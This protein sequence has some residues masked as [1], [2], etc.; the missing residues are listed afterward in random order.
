MGTGAGTG[1]MATTDTTATK[2]QE[3]DQDPSQGDNFV[4]TALFCA[5][6]EGNLKGLEE[7]FTVSNIDANQSNRHGE[8]AAHVAAGLGQLDILK[9][10]QS[11]GADLE[12][13]DNH[14]DSPMYWAARQGQVDIIKYLKEESLVSGDRNKAGESYLHVAARYGHANAVQ[15]LCSAGLDVNSQDQHGETALHIA[16]WHGFPRIVQTLCLAGANLNVLDK[17]EETP[18]HCA[19][20][21][22]HVD[23]VRCLIE[24]GANLDLVDKRGCTALHLAIKRH[25]TQVALL[26][27]HAGCGIDIP[28]SHHETPIHLVAREGNLPLA[29]TLCAFG[30]K[31]DIPNKGGFYPLH[32]AAKHAHIEIVRCLCLAGCKVDQKN[33]DGIIAEITALAQGY[34][35]IGDLLNK[36]QN[37]QLREEY[38]TQLIPGSQPLGRIK[39][40]F[41]GHSGVGKTTFVDSLKCGYFGS[42]FRRSRSSS[43]SSLTLRGQRGRSG[44]PNSKSTIELS[45][46]NPATSS[47][48]FD[49]PTDHY[50]RGIDVQ[51]ITV[52]GVGDV[53]VWEFS[54]QKPYFVVYD[55][56]IGNTN[57]IH[58]ILFNLNDPYDVQLQQV[59]FWLNFLLVRI[60]TQEPL[61]FCGKSSCPAKVVL[62]ATH[63]D[64][65]HCPRNATGEF[66]NSQAECLLYE[67]RHRFQHAFDIHDRVYV[68]SAHSP[69]NPST[70]AF[71]NFLVETKAKLVQSLPKSTGFLE[72]MVSHLPAWCRS[73]QSFP[74]LSWHQFVEM[75]HGQ[76]N[77]LAGEDHMRELIQQLQLMGEVLYLKS[78]SQDMVVLNPRWLCNTIV[79]Q[80]LS[81]QHLEQARVTGCYT[82]DD[83]QLLFP[84]LDALD[85]LQVLESLN[86]CTQCDN[87]G[88]IEYE[89]PCFNFVETLPGLWEKHDSRYQ[90]AVYGGV[91]IQTPKGTCHLLDSLFLRL[92][93]QLRRTAQEHHDPDNDL[94]QWYRGSKFCSGNLEGLLTLED[95]SESVEIK[96]RGPAAMRTACFYFLEDLLSV[97]D[98][99]VLEMCPSLL[100]EKHVLSAH[101][102]QGHVGVDED[103]TYEPK[104]LMEA[105]LCGKGAVRDETL[106]ELLC[107]GSEELLEGATVGRDLHVGALGVLVRQQLCR[108]LDPPDPMG[109]DWCLLAVQLGMVERLP[110]L[111]P[112][113]DPALLPSC[114]DRI[115]REWSRLPGSTVGALLTKLQGLGRGDT[116]DVLLQHCPLYRT[117]LD[118]SYDDDRHTDDLGGASHGSGNSS[119]NLSR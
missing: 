54:G 21:R 76:V 25:H 99:V 112:G 57:C 109:R 111:D 17:E 1:T 46:Q 10:L 110:H 29:Q 23:S 101:R 104:Q 115:L 64:V 7:L 16:V 92:Q 3:V 8:T 26:L 47:L 19:A 79:G 91:R 32:L 12:K 105:Q 69:S 35:D 106:A 75:V 93:V 77:P 53:S 9:F 15:Y 52:T 119:S 31:V 11:K 86:L 4:V 68:V 6:E 50:T 36:L 14:G 98:Q 85:L 55:H 56:F 66:L 83:F 81:H 62:I 70:K 30:C 107:F 18:L 24:A 60:P 13:P 58:G 38:I 97:V 94:Y 72:S 2:A 95:G 96:V 20:A 34:S 22:G 114:T 37:D 74:V 44:S 51:Q 28:D 59:T 108:L 41:F 102:L 45:S 48:S 39:L 40:K 118:G 49:S 27:L 63:A 87:D 90:D 42:L 100:I 73:S 103:A 116:V 89:F 113:S 117:A 88:D 71:K 61:G 84:E 82:V 80:L 5:V 78:D 33:K 43:G 65:V 67:V